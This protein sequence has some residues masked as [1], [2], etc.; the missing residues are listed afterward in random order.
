MTELSDTPVKLTENCFVPPGC[1]LAFTGL[2]EIV[3]GSTVI[4]ADACRP[5]TD[6]LEA[7]IV[8]VVLAFTE[9]GAEYIPELEIDPGPE[10]LQF[11]LGSLTP[12]MVTANCF[13]PPA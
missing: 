3:C 11:T 10:T 1:K 8:A 5:L 6:A 2:I 9:F 4:V 7:V 12:A 13:P